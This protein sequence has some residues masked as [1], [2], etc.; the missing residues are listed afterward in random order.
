VD[1]RIVQS[2]PP[3]PREVVTYEEQPR[4]D[5]VWTRGAYDWDGDGWVWVP[6]RWVARP[7]RHVY[8]VRARHIRR[9]GHWHYVPGHWSN[10]R[11]VYVKEKIK[12]K[13]SKH[14]G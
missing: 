9:H 6:G 8:W 13:K 5:D 11:V 4:P 2:A 7:A 10:Q 12:V 14:R 3:P 1:V